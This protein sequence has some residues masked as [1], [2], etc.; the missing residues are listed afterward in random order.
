MSV[1]WLCLL[2]DSKGLQWKHAFWCC[3]YCLL[4]SGGN[5]ENMYFKTIGCMSID[6]TVLKHIYTT[7]VMDCTDILTKFTI[8]IHKNRMPEFHLCWLDNNR[9]NSRMGKSHFHSRQ[10]TIWMSDSKRKMAQSQS[11]DCRTIANL[12]GLSRLP[13]M[14]EWFHSIYWN[15]NPNKSGP[16]MN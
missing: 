9:C 13:K 6:T 14:T 5:E 16:S 3:R 7:T 12:S 4:G 10:P 11:I 1:I 8:T 15:P 2:R